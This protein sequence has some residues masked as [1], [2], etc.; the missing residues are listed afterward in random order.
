MG[1]SLRN[2]DSRQI[3]GSG[4]VGGCERD[5]GAVHLGVHLGALGGELAALGV[6]LRDEFA[7]L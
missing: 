1:P 5:W 3:L 6:D 2:R 4:S 7:C